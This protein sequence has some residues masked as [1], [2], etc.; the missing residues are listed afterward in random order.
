MLCSALWIGDNGQKNVHVQLQ[1]FFLDG[2]D[3]IERIFF[4]TLCDGRNRFL[5]L[6]ESKA[7][8]PGIALTFHG[9]KN[10]AICHLSPKLKCFIT[11]S[12]P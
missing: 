11:G 3:Q 8:S 1:L 7:G 12:M 9:V 6:M 5:R 4:P 10:G 2:S